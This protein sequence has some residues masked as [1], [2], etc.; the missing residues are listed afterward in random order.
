M[1]QEK[2]SLLIL[3]KSH[4]PL[5]QRQDEISMLLYEKCN[6]YNIKVYIFLADN[7]IQIRDPLHQFNINITIFENI[8]KKLRYS[9]LIL[10]RPFLFLYIIFLFKKI[11]GKFKFDVCWTGDLFFASFSPILKLFGICKKFI[12][13]DPDYCPAYYSGILRII[14]TILESI[15]IKSSDII[16]SISEIL[17]KI[18]IRQG[19]KIVKVVPHMVD[20]NL[21]KAA[22]ETRLKRLYQQ[23]FKPKTILYAGN[24]TDLLKSDLLLHALNMVNKTGADFTFLLIGSGDKSVL[25][26]F[27]LTAKKMGFGSRVLYLGPISRNKMPE[28]FQRADIAIGKLALKYLYYGVTKK[29]LEYMAA[30]LPVIV[31][32]LGQP[33]LLVKKGNCGF[34][35]STNPEDLAGI[36]LKALKLSRDKIIELS[37]NARTLAEQY[38]YN[39]LGNKY[40]KL[41]EDV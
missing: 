20:C 17:A 4:H 29:I 3:N 25:D 9:Q 34:I 40:C 12:Y 14:V 31:T 35:S 24:I 13:D 32:D 27:I 11:F 28:I 10:I 15:A 39:I 6:T 2:R 16:I 18:R 41:L 26:N 38:D 36:I 1:K 5:T 37:K 33:K 21:F 8:F 22:Y 23:N 30:G 19:A 7:H